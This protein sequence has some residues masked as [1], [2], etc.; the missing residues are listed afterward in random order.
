MIRNVAPGRW[1]AGLDL[2]FFATARM[3][4]DKLAG[5]GLTDIKVHSRKERLPVNPKADPNYMDKWDTWVEATY[6]GPARAVDLGGYARWL[7]PD[8]VGPPIPAE[9]AKPAAAIPPPSKPKA[10]MGSLGLIIA[11]AIALYAL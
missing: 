7:V 5:L 1:Y 2:P 11:A 6:P 4:S 8:S 10:P 3:V 9:L